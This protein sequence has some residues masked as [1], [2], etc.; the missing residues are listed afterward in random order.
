MDTVRRPSR[1]AKLHVPVSEFVRHGNGPSLSSVD[2]LEM[3]PFQID[4]RE[5][6]AI[7]GD[8][9]VDHAII[10]GINRELPYFDLRRNWLQLRPSPGGPETQNHEA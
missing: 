3:H 1:T 7:R 4:V 5:V 8:D 9:P 10:G 2:Y 6:L